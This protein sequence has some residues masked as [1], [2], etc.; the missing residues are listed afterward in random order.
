MKNYTQKLQL[1]DGTIAYDLPRN[2]ILPE[3]EYKYVRVPW[4]SHYT[5]F[6]LA[7][8]LYG[9]VNDFYLIMAANRTYKPLSR[10]EDI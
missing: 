5:L 4:F 3:E 1:D 9:D 10:I 7:Y 2:V 8:M 6:K